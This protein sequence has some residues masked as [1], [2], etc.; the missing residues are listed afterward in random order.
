LP[1]KTKR[2]LFNKSL[3]ENKR[4]STKFNKKLKI[5]KRKIIDFTK[6]CLNPRRIWIDRIR[7]GWRRLDRDMWLRLK[8]EDKTT[9]TKWTLTSKDLTSYQPKRKKTQE[10]SK[11]DS[12]NS[13][14]TTRKS[15]R[16]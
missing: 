5:K 16:N 3:I 10:S 4:K 11:S 9:P 15:L 14:F 2:H 1:N 6:N 13:V 7:R 12:M 8:G